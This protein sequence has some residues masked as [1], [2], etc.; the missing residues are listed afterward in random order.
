MAST[1][2]HPFK[3][4]SALAV[5]LLA[6]LPAVAAPR[7]RLAFLGLHGDESVPEPFVRSVSEFTQSQVASLGD[8]EV[9]GLGDIDSLLG[10][11]RKKQLLGC[12]ADTSCLTEI[13]GALGVE[14]ALT[15][16][17]SR[18]GDS[19]LLNFSLLDVPAARVVGRVGRRVDAG[20]SL[21]PVLDAV[22]P[23]LEELAGLDGHRGRW[24]LSA[25]ARGEYDAKA[26]GR[27]LAVAAV[28]QGPVVGLQATV[29]GPPVGLRLEVRLA[30]VLL[31]VVRP[32]LTAGGA[33]FPDTAALRASGGVEVRHGQL[34][35]CADVGFEHYLRQ[36]LQDA[37]LVAAGAGWAF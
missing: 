20:S 21:E 32:Y 25:L 23:A 37:L 8:Y 17:V 16:N 15:A 34:R 19:V 10:L 4:W 2:T 6:A 9:I 29:V 14:R 3:R 27:A 30:P 12:D 11:E 13:G 36:E 35:V 22:R 5:L 28:F 24:A 31:G 1:R 33:L 7:P 18:V 26:G